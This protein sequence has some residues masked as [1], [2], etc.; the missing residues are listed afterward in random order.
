VP[1][2]A[3]VPVQSPVAAHDVAL[4]VLHVSVEVLPWTI[5]FGL[6]LSAKVGGGLGGVTFTVTDCEPEPPAPLHVST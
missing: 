5:A 4:V 2:V 3:L 1:L 6:A